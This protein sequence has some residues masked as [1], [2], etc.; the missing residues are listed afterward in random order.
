MFSLFIN[1][2]VLKYVSFSVCLEKYCIFALS[3]DE[4]SVMDGL[5]TITKRSREKKGI[6]IWV[7][8]LEIKVDDET[9]AKLKNFVRKL[10]G[11]YSN[12]HGTENFV[13]KFRND[14]RIFCKKL[15]NNLLTE[16]SD[17]SCKFELSEFEY[18]EPEK[19]K[20][21]CNNKNEDEQEVLPQ[22]Y[23][24]S[25]QTS[26]L[27]TKVTTIEYLKKNN[28]I[29][30][31]TYN[32]FKKLHCEFVG[33]I[34]SNF[35]N[36]STLH[37]IK[38]LGEKSIAE[39]KFVLANTDF[40]LQF[41]LQQGD[42]KLLYFTKL[43]P[44]LNLEEV[45]FV[46]QYY[47]DNNIEPFLYILYKYIIHSND[48][49]NI[50]YCHYCGFYGNT[51]MSTLDIAY[52]YNLTRERV[53]QI[54][55]K[56]LQIDEMTLIRF[57]SVPINNCLLIDEQSNIYA[58][59]KKEQN[60]PLEFNV[61]AELVSI[62][63]TFAINK[64]NGHTCLLNYKRAFDFDCNDFIQKCHEE[65][66]WRRNTISVPIENILG[67]GKSKDTV[68]LAK[69]IAKKYLN[70]P[71][72]DNDELIFKQTYI[73]YENAI[74]WI[75]FDNK[76]PM[77]LKDIIPILKNK[78]PNWVIKN[79]AQIRED[80]YSR[81]RIISEYIEGSSYKLYKADVTKASLS[82]DWNDDENDYA[83]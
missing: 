7:V 25:E 73:D 51:P 64:I 33:D 27:F 31:R 30:T 19:P 17:G 83:E 66:S 71:I 67:K 49:D 53:R 43:Y 54:I 61:F 60:I 55:H 56:S 81:K 69:I 46:T 48:R 57:N 76:E 21:L 6:N 41:S 62:L 47:N 14:A 16:E 32:C 4:N 68:E 40:N 38:G 22:L 2:V 35:E 42:H 82:L 75:L 44:F 1:S 24:K 11:H 39:I 78:Y 15:D 13:F 52:K 12:F 70:I 37:S 77:L 8:R 79:T 65:S 34:V 28:Y 20:I 23:D 18:V 9:L 80:M 74:Y 63:G 59:I 10:R 50:I 58:C 45:K 72:T 29:S 26:T 36:S 3:I 5:Y